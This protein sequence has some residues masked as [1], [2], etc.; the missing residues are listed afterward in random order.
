MIYAWKY[1]DSLY[2]SAMI[3]VN[4]PGHFSWEP[5]VVDQQLE[6]DAE[7]CAKDPECS[8]RTRPVPKLGRIFVCAFSKGICLLSLR[9]SGK[10][11]FQHSTAPIHGHLP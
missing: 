5:D 9:Q 8:A 1:P 2:R 10:M 7:L 11:R 3:A 4:P 6:Y